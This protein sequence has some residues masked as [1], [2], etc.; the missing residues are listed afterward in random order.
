MKLCKI[1]TRNIVKK[2]KK[3]VAFFVKRFSRV[4]VKFWSKN[5]WVL[6]Q[7]MFLKKNLVIFCLFCQGKLKRVILGGVFLLPQG[8]F[9]TLIRAKAKGFFVFVFSKERKDEKIV[10]NDIDKPLN[11]I[12]VFIFLWKS[13]YKNFFLS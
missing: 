10:F 8:P 6:R 5:H 7:V 3:N 1:V 4:F 12:S 9:L 11:I 2:E 13:A